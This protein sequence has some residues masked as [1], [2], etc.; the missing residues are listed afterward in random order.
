MSVFNGI[1][2]IPLHAFSNT[3]NK[4]LLNNKSGILWNGTVPECPP[5]KDGIEN[6]KDLFQMLSL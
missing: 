1:L 6:L 3:D 2:H 4:W 5:G